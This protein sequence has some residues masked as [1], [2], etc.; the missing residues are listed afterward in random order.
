MLPWVPL[1]LGAFFLWFSK[2]RTLAFALLGVGYLL[3]FATG[4]LGTMAALALLLPLVS[5]YAMKNLRRVPWQVVLHIV[6]ILWALALTLHLFLGFH[7]LHVLGPERFTPDAA[8]FTLYLNFDKPLVG[9][10]LVLVL[11]QQLRLSQDAGRIAKTVLLTLSATTV[12][13][14]G[15]AFTIGFLRWEPKMPHLA[16]VWA[17]NNLLLVAPS[18]EALF[19]GYLQGGLERIL[20]KFASGKWIALAIASL[21]FGLA[22]AAGGWQ[23]VLMAS[24]A[25]VGYGMAYRL[26]G[27]R[28]SILTHFGL[29]L[30]HFSLFTYPMLSR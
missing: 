14:L 18:E 9:F 3:G 10:F 2:F 23:W 28:A 30:L 13:C 12:A 7:N 8:P 19:R 1:F 21:L 16:W 24:L 26:A 4:Q 17:A 20:S 27:L 15:L 5:G 6:F 11:S 25:G 29:N 22:H